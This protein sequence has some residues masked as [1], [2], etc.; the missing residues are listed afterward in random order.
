[1]EHQL[2]LWPSGNIRYQFTAQ[3]MEILSP[4]SG[5]DAQS[6]SNGAV[7]HGSETEQQRQGK[8]TKG[9]IWAQN[10]QKTMDSFTKSIAENPDPVPQ[11]KPQSNGSK[12]TRQVK[13]LK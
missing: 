8:P 4:N 9:Q 5:I 7:S 13:A 12:K 6:V 3:D 2:P 11:T 10:A 1:M